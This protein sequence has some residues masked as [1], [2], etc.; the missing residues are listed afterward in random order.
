MNDVYTFVKSHPNYLRKRY[1]KG[2]AYSKYRLCLGV[3]AKS[4][5]KNKLDQRLNRAKKENAP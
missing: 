3:A 4:R 1:Q 2:Y 5:K